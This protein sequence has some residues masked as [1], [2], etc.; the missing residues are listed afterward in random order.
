MVSC[1]PLLPVRNAPDSGRLRTSGGRLKAV[2]E[3]RS[4]R[5]GY[6]K[7][8]GGPVVWPLSNISLQS[9]DGPEIHADTWRAK[10]QAFPSD[11]KGCSHD[12]Q[13]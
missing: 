7:L 9:R 11:K 6:T 12:P 8:L 2:I 10:V 1:G 3:H 5:Y 4:L 13:T